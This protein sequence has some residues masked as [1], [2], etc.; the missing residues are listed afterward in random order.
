MTKQLF[1]LLGLE[2][3]KKIHAPL[4]NPIVYNSKENTDKFYSDAALVARYE[5]E[6]RISFYTEIINTIEQT[7]GFDKVSSIADVSAGTG[8]LLKEFRQKFPDKK[9]YGFE[10]SDDALALCKKNCPDI[11]FEKIDL[12]TELNRT[13]DLILCVDTLEHLEYPEKAIQNILDMLT[14][15]AHLC[16]IVPN[17]RYDT[18]EGHIHYWSPESFK[19]F[20]EKINC[21]IRYAMVWDKYVEQCVIVKRKKTIY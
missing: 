13:F 20:L 14:P 19:L 8:R 12:Y 9:Y 5:D 1:N 11:P 21:E 6:R 3:R 17:G 7:F 2:V 4:N 10:F 16:L 15:N 18:F